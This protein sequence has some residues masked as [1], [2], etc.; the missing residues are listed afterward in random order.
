M[1]LNFEIT[2]QDMVNWQNYYVKNHASFFVKNIK[3]FVIIP[4]VLISFRT[5]SDLSQGIYGNVM[6]D[7]IFPIGLVAL[8]GYYYFGKGG[9]YARAMKKMIKNNPQLTG[10]REM[11]F[12]DE[13]FRIQTPESNSEIRY[14]SLFKW[15]STG[16]YEYLFQSK[17]IA[18]IIPRHVFADELEYQ[19]FVDL[20]ENRL[21][22][23]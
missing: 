19:A 23:A 14:D 21:E 9:F 17:Q 2:T 15:E 6:L 5:L 22:M 10:E 20:M 1:K 16:E 18:F 4:M 8:L 13:T 3:W 11:E 12:K 7:L